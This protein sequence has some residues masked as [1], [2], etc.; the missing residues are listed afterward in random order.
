MTRYDR[1]AHPATKVMA[2]IAFLIGLGIVMEGANQAQSY[3][4]GPQASASVASDATDGRA[5]K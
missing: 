1:P 5:A 3:F 2:F 4:A